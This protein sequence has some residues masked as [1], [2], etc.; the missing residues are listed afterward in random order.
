MKKCSII[1]QDLE[2]DIMNTKESNNV[3]TEKTRRI[4]MTVFGV[5]IC[6]FSVGMFNFSMFGMDPFQVFV[7]G[8]WI[9]LPEGF[10]RGAFS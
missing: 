9:A 10:P 8:I 2:E 4:L 6:G 5:L 3:M 7:H 1:M